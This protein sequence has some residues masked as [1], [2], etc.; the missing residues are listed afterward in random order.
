M[1]IYT[2]WQHTLW[3]TCS[4]S[5]D[6][7]FLLVI[8]W[9]EISQNHFSFLGSGTTKKSPCYQTPRA[10]KCAIMSDDKPGSWHQVSTYFP[11]AWLILDPDHW[12]KTVLSHSNSVLCLFSLL[13]VHLQSKKHR[14]HLKKKRKSDPA[15]DQSQVT[16]APPASAAEIVES[17]SKDSCATVA[18]GC[19][20]A[21]QESSQDTRTTHE[22]VPVAL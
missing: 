4:S 7:P 19:S 13:A 16:T 1:N 21:S 10:K 17:L 3:T 20:E 18:P 6:K 22:E 9:T 12:D 15:C 14:Y 5:P 2:Q 8:I 11:R